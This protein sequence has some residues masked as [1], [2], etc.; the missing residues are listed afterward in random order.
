MSGNC[1]HLQ[2]PDLSHL[3]HLLGT[4]VWHEDIIV[5][6]NSTSFSRSFLLPWMLFASLVIHVLLLFL[7]VNPVEEKLVSG[8]QHTLQIKLKPIIQQSKTEL[9]E[10]M[11]K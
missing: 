1:L 5:Q 4:G 3:R 10:S 7:A 2:E 8:Q 9:V 11:E 6:R